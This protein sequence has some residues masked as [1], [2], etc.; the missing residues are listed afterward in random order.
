MEE[1]EAAGRRAMA[2]AGVEGAK[3]RWGEANGPHPM[4]ALE[5]SEESPKRNPQSRDKVAALVGTSGRA[6]TKMKRIAKERPDLQEK[7][8]SGEMSLHEADDIIAASVAPPAREKPAI[9]SAS[10]QRHALDKAIVALSGIVFGLNQ[11]TEIHPQITNEEAAEWI[12]GLSKARRAIDSLI[13][14]L[15]GV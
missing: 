9:S 8:R 3:K 6:V 12:D 1:Q 11:I 4:E 15:R 13:N 2:L 10:A 7:I 5:G 14:R